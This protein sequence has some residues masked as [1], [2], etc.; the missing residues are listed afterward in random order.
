VVR[1]L[2]GACALALIV[3]WSG[4]RPATPSESDWRSSARQA[5]S[6]VA[7]EV[8]TARLSVQQSLEDS[9]VGRYPAVVLTYSEE[10]AGD[11]T[12]KVSTQQ[13][14][15]QE[16]TRYDHVVGELGDATDLITAA[17]IAVAD[18]DR[19]AARGLLRDLDKTVEDLHRLE[20]ELSRP[21]TGSG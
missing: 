6:D 10:A 2:T 5:A 18:D 17:R 20:S 3:A 7:S 12:D 14:P 15:D 19:A 1:A 21:P 13:P 11:A 4:C 9:F 16:R 8:A